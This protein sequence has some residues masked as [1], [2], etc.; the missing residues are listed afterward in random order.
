MGGFFGAVSGK[1]CVSDVFFGTDFHSHLGTVRGGMAIVNGDRFH[2]AIH[3]ITNTQFRS[4]FDHDFQTF[5]KLGSHA[6][7]GIISDHDDQPLLI[8]S[9]LGIYAIVT[10]GVL[11]NLPE[12]V[13]ELYQREGGTHL[14]ELG[15]GAINPTE[16]VASMINTKDTFAEGIQ[17]AQSRILGSC[18][19]LVLTVDG[20]LYAARDRF[21]RTPIAL[22]EKQDGYAVATESCSFPNTGYRFIRDLGCGEVVE[23][24]NGGVE[25]VVRPSNSS[26]AICAFLWVY[27][28]YPASTIEDRNVEET[29]YRCGE[30]LARHNP[31]DA[32]CVA[33]VPD[34]G[35]GHA[36][37]YAAAT[38]IRYARPFVK[39]TPT[40]PRSFM[41]T[42]QS[43]RD[44]IAQMKLIPIPELI[45]GKRMIFCDDSIVRGTQ[46]RDQVNR[47]NAAGAK[48]IHM[49][50]AC[51]P[52][53]Y[54]C[55]FIN[56]SRSRSAM[57]LITRR[58]IHELDGPH[59]DIA[60][61]QD[62]DERPYKTMVEKIRFRLGLTTLAYQR[63]DDLHR[64]IDLP[65]LCTY[66]WTGKDVSLDSSC[67][68]GCVSCAKTSCAVRS[69]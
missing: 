12:L 44:Q 19:I 35:I 13:A 38:G 31:V 56:F 5:N 16:V 54:K 69:V 21:G 48:E 1:S 68:P 47:L 7:I 67:A 36:L 29:R 4:K 8:A 9:H 2:R 23:L 27:F 25:T 59:A 6:G 11:I 20:R 33:G 26:A 55:R 58:V 65:G 32:D 10:V 17:Y 15:G 14:S 41:P 30:L 64:A 46:L 61:Y 52:L 62:P 40:W 43:V 51:P 50:I 37:G 18:S 28:A 57:D 42:D 53:L 22:G 39:Y 45:K 63:I 34:S 24:S 49:R 60:R 3:D 66:C